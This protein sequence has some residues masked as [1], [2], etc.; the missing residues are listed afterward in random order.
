MR[1]KIN[2]PKCFL[3]TLLGFYLNGCSDFLGIE[4]KPKLIEREVTFRI[5]FRD[6]SGFMNLLFGNDKVRGAEVNLKSNLLGLEYNLVTDSSG[7]ISI[8]GIISDKYIITANRFMTPDEMQIISGTSASNVKLVNRKQRIIELNASSTQEI[9][10]E[11]DMVVGSSDLVISEI[12]ACG[13]PG[14]GLYYHD[15][16]VEIFN[17]SDFDYCCCLC[18]CS[19]MDTLS[20]R[21]R[22]RSFKKYLVFPW[23]WYGLSNSAG[24][25]YTLCS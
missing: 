14:A 2:F 11:M 25:I 16:Y 17:Q 12:Y 13:P 20:R 15:K 22:L 18:S 23:K 6:N 3:I 9:N 7:T 8:N 19:Y 10:I 4:S 1:Q 21:P 5:V 24:A